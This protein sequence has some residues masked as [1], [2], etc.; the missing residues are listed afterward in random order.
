LWI[1]GY[2]PLCSAIAVPRPENYFNVF[3]PTTLAKLDLHFEA[4]GQGFRRKSD[5]TCHRFATGKMAGM[6]RKDEKPWKPL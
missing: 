2:C 1:D 6:R 5:K 3:L 4:M